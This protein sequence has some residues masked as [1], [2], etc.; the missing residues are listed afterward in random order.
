MRNLALL[1]LLNFGTLG[2]LGHW[3]FGTWA[4][5]HLG[6]SG[7]HDMKDAF[8]FPF[9]PLSGQG[10]IRLCGRRLLDE[11]MIRRSVG[12]VRVEGTWPRG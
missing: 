1:A 11:R 5:G 12:G 6:M 7:Q 3:Y 2:Y 4:L 9:Y 8:V 10:G